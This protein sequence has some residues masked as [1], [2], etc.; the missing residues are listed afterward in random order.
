MRAES[1]YLQ[2]GLWG[3]LAAVLLSVCGVFLY[4]LL[5]P[6][7]PPLPVYGQVPDFKLTNQ[8]D[9]PVTLSSL[10]GSVW[11]GD[12]IFTRC[13][14]PCLQMTRKMKAVQDQLPKSAPVKLVSLTADPTFDTP[15]ILKQYAARF[16][17]QSGRWEFLTGPK[18]DV[19]ALAMEGLKL[20]VQEN[21][22]TNVAEDA[23]IHSTRFVLVDRSGRLRGV[24]FEGEDEGAVPDLVRAVAQLV[25]EK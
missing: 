11:V 17:A 25:K 13:P 15:P 18:R 12:I 9:Q 23:F 22:N 5:Q 21:P 24:S 4:T 19:Y 1:R 20:A 7:L 10:R 6:A 2:W 16:Q 14:G 3:V 8:L